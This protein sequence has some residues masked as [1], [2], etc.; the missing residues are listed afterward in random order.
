MFSHNAA[1]YM[2]RKYRQKKGFTVTGQ[3]IDPVAIL[4]NF[5]D[6]VEEFQRGLSNPSLEHGHEGDERQDPK[7][8]DFLQER[9]YSALAARMRGEDALFAMHDFHSAAVDSDQGVGRRTP[10]LLDQAT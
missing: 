1:D 8:S 3:Q 7:F 10:Q 4:G 9:G 2:P 5:L 6:L